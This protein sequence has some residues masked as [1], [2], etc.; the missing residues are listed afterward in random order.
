MRVGCVRRNDK[1]VKHGKGILF[2]G[3]SELDIVSQKLRYHF[4]MQYCNLKWTTRVNDCARAWGR[5]CLN[6]YL[7]IEAM[8][9]SRVMSELDD[10][11]LFDLYRLNAAI[12]K[13]LDDP[14]RIEEVKRL[15]KEG[16][17]IS[18]FDKSE[19]RLIQADV[20]EFKRTRVLVKNKHDMKRW[21]IPFYMVNVEDVATDITYPTTTKGMNRN[22]I[23]IGDLV[24]FRSKS[25][26]NV[27]GKVMRMNPKTVTVFVEP[28]QKWRVSYS[29]LYPIIDGEK[30]DEHKFIEGVVIEREPAVSV[31]G[32]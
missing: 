5:Y 8:D 16:D 4:A 18:Y 25:N 14:K 2:L 23:R 21:N 13:E 24:G 30:A 3:C 27:R 26:K 28:N 10:A 15:I 20:I 22:E 12:S 6:Y 29:M 1:F 32:R 31:E 17:T 19:N 7:G 9:Y 11:S